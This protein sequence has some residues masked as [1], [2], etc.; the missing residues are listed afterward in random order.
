LL[1]GLYSSGSQ[2]YCEKWNDAGEDFLFQNFNFPI[3]Y[4]KDVEKVQKILNCYNKF[5]R[6]IDPNVPRDWPLCAAELKAFMLAAVDTPTCLR[7]SER[8]NLEQHQGDFIKR[9]IS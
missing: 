2:H 6:P 3:F 1:T 9:S 4:V 7:R 5:N 8:F